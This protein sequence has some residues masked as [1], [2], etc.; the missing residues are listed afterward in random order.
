MGIVVSFMIG[1]AIYF[2]I[3]S[4]PENFFVAAREL[5]LFITVMTLAAQAID[6]NAL[7]GNADLSYKFSIWDGLVLPVGLALSLVL[8]GIFFAHKIHDDNVLT[9][10]DVYAKRYG[11]IV[12]VLV[13]IATLISFMM[14][15]AGNLVGMGVT[16]AYT[17]GIEE[18]GA[19]WISSAI[20]WSCTVSKL[21]NEKYLSLSD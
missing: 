1:G 8:N 9:L 6:S 7:L 13:S 15:L 5:P 20:V 18:S 12:E 10:P 2:L 21:G 4:T 11:K 19:I 16:L 14:L 3:E 17:T